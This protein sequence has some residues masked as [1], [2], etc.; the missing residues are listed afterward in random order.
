MKTNRM[1]LLRVIEI[2]FTMLFLSA[3]LHAEE[4][5]PVDDQQQTE[6]ADQ[7]KEEAEEIE[8]LEPE[9][10]DLTIPPRVKVFT[11]KTRSEDNPEVPFY[12]R[13]PKK[14]A[15]GQVH[16]LLFICPHYNGN[17]L[18]YLK[19]HYLLELADERDWFVMTCTF[20]SKG[21]VRDRKLCY[22][23]PEKFSGKAVLEALK[24]VSEK[25][26]V[27][28]ERLLMQGLSGGAQFVHRF[29]MWAP[30]RVSA[31][32]VN[33]SSWF[34]EPTPSSNQV[35][36]LVTIG[37][38]DPSYN[39][40][41][42]FVDKLRNVGVAPFFRSYVGMIHEGTSEVYQL[43]QEI[44]KFYDD[45]TKKDLGEKR[46]KL[47]PESERL[48]LQAKQ[49]PFVG[50]TQQW[51]FLPNSEENEESI[52]EDVRVYLPSEELAKIWGVKKEEE[53]E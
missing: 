46:S 11:V 29:A 42:E 50:D 49:M 47:T 2:F 12:L 7:D 53:K 26:P 36:W 35:A 32:A 52:A 19:A 34:D 23:Y 43:N 18:D 22:Y 4:P 8:K 48:A 31:V 30:E 25:Y 33:S 51:E 1:T 5:K 14:H 9:K 41:I 21:N 27:D 20:K 39:N 3:M 13:I 38:S 44:L 45:F 28:T 37:E 40:S 10:E 6:E 24:L 17:G 15:K 16:R